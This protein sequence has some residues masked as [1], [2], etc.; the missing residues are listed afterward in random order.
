MA[1]I[2]Q[3]IPQEV[4]VDQAGRITLG[5]SLNGKMFKVSVIETGE[6]RLVPARVVPDN[7]AWFFEDPERVKLFESSLKQSLLGTEKEIS[8]EELNDL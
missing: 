2:Q 7:E 4:R 8:L 1:T 5:K 6:I 3:K